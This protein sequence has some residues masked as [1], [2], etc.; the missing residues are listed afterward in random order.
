MSLPG[1]QNTL[2][3]ILKYLEDEQPHKA[4]DTFAYVETQ[5]DLTEE[6]A[7]TL[8]KNGRTRLMDRVLW[9]I[10]YL[11]KACLIESVSR[12]VFR[13]TSRGKML[14]AKNPK[15][16]SMKD[17]EQY[18][19]YLEFRGLE[20][21]NGELNESATSTHQSTPQEDLQQIIETIRDQIE[22]EL[23]DTLKTISPTFFEKVVVGLLEKMGYGGFIKGAGSTT[24]HSGDDGIDGI[25]K[26]D[27]LGL[28]LI[29]IQAKRYT[30]TVVGRPEIQS[31]AGSLEGQ[32]GRKGV[33][34]TTSSFSSEAHEYVKRIE[35][36][37][38]LIDGTHLSH[39]CFDFGIGVTDEPS[40]VIKK[41]DPSFFDE[42]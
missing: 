14:L 28:D 39:L 24:K 37:I 38:V 40:Y 4:K 31:F 25:I 33:F 1:F 9:A 16:L 32:H 2:L 5:F 11:S 13:I 35:K 29:H 27:R 7:T 26:E 6:E 3:P 42:T 41:F 36:K 23:L 12:G 30:T 17:L 20:K 22:V 34:I 8:L 10:T 21:T 19:E 18:P 15:T